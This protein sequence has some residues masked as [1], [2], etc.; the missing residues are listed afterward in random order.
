MAVHLHAYACRQQCGTAAIVHVGRSVVLDV[1]WISA[2]RNNRREATAV[3]DIR[4]GIELQVIRQGATEDGL[5]A[6]RSILSEHNQDVTH[7]D[8]A[9]LIEV[10]AIRGGNAVTTANAV[11]IQSIAETVAV[12]LRNIIAATAI[13]G[14]WAITDTACVDGADTVV[15]VVA[16]AVAVLIRCA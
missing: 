9:V 13:N 12:P 14:A 2:T 8:G 15:L 3:V 6:R 5:V 4:L 10:R 1:G 7:P 16:D 11:G